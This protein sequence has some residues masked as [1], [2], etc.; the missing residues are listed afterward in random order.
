MRLGGHVTNEAIRVRENQAGTDLW[1]IEIGD[2]REELAVSMHGERFDELLAKATAAR[3]GD[4]PTP[5]QRE[6]ATPA[7]VE[8]STSRIAGASANLRHLFQNRPNTMPINTW[9]THVAAVV[10]AA[11][12]LAKGWNGGQ[13]KLGDVAEL[14]RAVKALDGRP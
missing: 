2:G 7:E 3:A 11:Q 14:M 12:V 8:H 6:D 13:P 5:A 4:A 10:E 9:S 1:V